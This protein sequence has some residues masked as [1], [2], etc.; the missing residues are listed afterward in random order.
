[1]NSI[2]QLCSKCNKH[3]TIFLNKDNV[4]INCQCGNYFTMQINTFIN[5]FN[6]NQSNVVNNNNTFTDT[7]TDIKYSYK[8]LLSYFIALKEEHIN[9]LLRAINQI[10]SSYEECYNRNK[11]I[12]KNI[13]SFI[14]ILINNYDGSI[15]MKNN[16]MNN[17]INIY[18]CKENA[19][20]NDI[21]KYYNEYNI[22]E[23]KKIEEIKCI[24]TITKDID[25][26]RSL[27]ILKDK[28]VASCSDDS[29]IKIY[30]PANDY[31]C[32]QVIKRHT[33]GI[34]SICELDDGTIVSCSWDK[35]IIIGDYTIKN[36]HNDCINKVI[37]LPNNRIASCSFDKTIKI[38]KS[39]P[40]YSDTPIK[41]LEGHSA[42]IM[43]L[44]YIKEKDIMIS[45]SDVDS[46]RLWNMS[47]YQSDKVI[48]GVKCCSINSLYQID[49]DRVIVGGF[50]VFYIVNIDKCVIEKIVEYISNVLCFLKMRDNTILCGCSYELFCFDEMKTK[51]Y[52]I[53]KN[54]HN[55]KIYDLLKIDDN[56]F[57]SCSN[58]RTIKVWKY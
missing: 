36:A 18:K 10:E 38:W 44:L 31:H 26:V 20:A 1:M 33:R 21:I 34:N 47:T 19:N 50:I 52:K 58:D 25:Y 41:V 42:K 54:N 32:D 17:K 56:T 43:S 49:E 29:T 37:T 16:I 46:L 5:Q 11:N 12:L 2:L 8:H 39:N 53:T 35:S 45:G 9:H 55:T 3:T 14:Q 57:L 24:K 51:K 7:I 22:I 27:L 13:L 48:E 30:D 28:K 4:H 6:Y 40:P 23:H 15:E